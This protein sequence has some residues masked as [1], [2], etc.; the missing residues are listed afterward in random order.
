MPLLFGRRRGGQGFFWNGLV[1]EVHYFV[2]T[3]LSNA[4][5][6]AIYDAGSNGVCDDTCGDTVVDAGE[7]C[8]D[9]N[10]TNGDGCDNNC[11]FTGCGNGIATG[12]EACDDGNAIDTDGCKSDC[13]LN[14]CG[15][16]VQNIGVEA[17]DDGNLDPGDGCSATCVPE[18]CGNGILD[19]GEDCD[20][21]NTVD[22][23][24]C[25]A[26]CADEPCGDNDLDPGEECDDGN[27][28]NGDGCT[29]VCTIQ[30]CGNGSLELGEECDDGNVAD[31]DSCSSQCL[32]EGC[33][34]TGT[35]SGDD[36][37]VGLR[38]RFID[39]G[40]GTV[41]GGYVLPPDLD[42]VSPLAGT[43][44]GTALTLSL[45]F[46]IAATLIDC[47]TLEFTSPFVFTAT[48]LS[49]TLCGD[50]TV[51]F[52]EECDDGNFSNGDA[53]DANCRL[54]DCGNGLIDQGEEC[55]DANAVN[56]DA[57]D[58]NCP[59]P[60][61]GNAALDPD[62]QCDDGN[63]ADGDGCSATCTLPNCPN[64][65]VDPGEECDDGNQIDGDSCARNCLLPRCGNAI[66]ESGE[67][68][69]DGNT[70]DCDGC[71]A[72]CGAE[73]DAD[74]DGV[75]DACDNCPNDFNPSQRDRDDNGLGDACD[76]PVEAP[77]QAG[78][79]VT[80][81]VDLGSGSG[82]APNPISALS[83]TFD[84]AVSAGTT[85]VQVLEAAPGEVLNA[86]FRV[87]G[88]GVLLHIDTTAST[89]GPITLCFT[90]E[91]SLLAPG[92]EPLLRF[93][94]E[95]GG[96]FVDRT[97]SLDVDANLL[98][99]VVTSFSRFAFGIGVNAADK[100][101]LKVKK[102]SVSVGQDRLR[103][104]VAKLLPPGQAAIDPSV[105]GL[106]VV[107]LQAGQPVFQRVIAGAQWT[108][109]KAN[110]SF[111][112]KDD[113]GTLVSG[114]TKAKVKRSS[115]GVTV[116]LTGINLDFRALDGSDLELRCDF[117][118]VTFVAPLTCTASAPGDTVT[119]KC[120]HAP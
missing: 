29:A 117:G 46:D 114:I 17:C 92:E 88:S 3:A 69:D 95:E 38:T 13:T 73:A 80:V 119:V 89:S 57:C 65:A 56:G 102:T 48:R 40:N 78:D 6:Q 35:W 47:D 107:L 60:R 14:V 39:D 109:V 81:D 82:L 44:V 58:T 25:S 93:L 83:I 8:D 30:I 85:S 53:C 18:E 116:K 33:N 98:C 100:A 15:D 79:E 71:S 99:G 49:A 2:G 5:I 43:R 16:G 74:D 34:I 37:V 66:P 1:D 77:T 70:A 90:Y 72:T 12:S 59:T 101:K 11:T 23:D 104:L 94:H 120:S 24:G 28:D 51:N 62:E 86:N 105:T 67:T 91:E 36:F 113:T 22:G 55:D 111:R 7:D 103:R 112:F 50:G 108:V 9:G 41:S 10:L 118:A 75:A 64:G 110:K 97:T 31:G 61:C 19:P 45:P 32:F 4:E 54:P 96:T 26:M 52:G 27:H 87:A 84:L 68:C 106:R 21:S 42:T 20:D 115:S 76:A 63:E